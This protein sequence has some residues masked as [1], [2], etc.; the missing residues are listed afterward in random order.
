[1]VNIKKPSAVLFDL[2]GTA[3]KTGFTDRVLFVYLRENV[4][5]FV[6]NR[7]NE[8]PHVHKDIDTLRQLSETDGGPRIAPDTASLDEIEASVV[9]YTLACLDDFNRREN[10][11]FQQF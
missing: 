1:M 8:N 5:T 4:G 7:Y 11:S 6:H 10:H 2:W 3:I 9:A